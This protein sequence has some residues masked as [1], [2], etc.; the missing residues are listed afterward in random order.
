MSNELQLEPTYVS[1]P[2]F[3]LR[4]AQIADAEE[5]T[6]LW[7]AS[8]NTSNIFW[9][10]A[11]PDDPIT[12]KWFDEVWIMGIKAGKDV[13]RTLVIEDLSKAN[14]LVA[15]GRFQPPQKD[16]RNVLPMPPVP[17]HWDPEITDGCFGG[18]ARARA[19]LMG[20]KP[21]WMAQYIGI[22]EAYQNKRLAVVFM[23]WL[24]KRADAANLDCYADASMKGY[25]VWKHYGWVEQPGPTARVSGRLGQFETY[26]LVPIIRPA[27]SSSVSVLAKL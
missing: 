13:V 11:T 21:H 18:M 7:Y 25:A 20:A 15:F 12:R 9:H 5:I 8:F 10:Y 17:E 16:G 24:F 23:D 4:D 14:R 19:R 27:R 22:D 2:G 1:P 26:E 6:N 3:R